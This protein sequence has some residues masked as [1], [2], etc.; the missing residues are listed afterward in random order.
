MTSEVM[1]N[2]NILRTLSQSSSKF[3][4][5]DQQRQNAWFIRYLKETRDTAFDSQ[6]KTLNYG[7]L[8]AGAPL[9]YLQR[10]EINHTF[11]EDSENSNRSRA[12]IYEILQRNSFSRARE[13][14]LW[15]AVKVDHQPRKSLFLKKAGKLDISQLLAFEKIQEGI[16]T[17]KKSYSE[18]N[19]EF[20]KAK[21]IEL[22]SFN[23][24]N[25]TTTDLQ[26]FGRFAQLL[27]PKELSEL[28]GES[29]TF[30]N[31][32]V[33]SVVTPT[34]S[35]TQLTEIYKRF[36]S[37]L[38]ESERDTK[39]VNTQLFPALSSTDLLSS[40]PHFIWTEHRDAL[41]EASDMF[42][43]AQMSALHELIKPGKWNSA[44]MSSILTN[45]PKCLDDDPPKKVMENLDLILDGVETVPE[46]FYDI[47]DKL[48]MIPRHLKMAWLETSLADKEILNTDDLLD[49]PSKDAALKE[50]I[51]NPDSTHPLSHTFIKFF[52]NDDSSLPSLVLAGLSCKHI[53]MI[54][55]YDSLEV[56]AL[57]R[58][59]VDLYGDLMPSS[60]R[61][62]WA[63][64]VREFLMF[65]ASVLNI[66]MTTETE[67]LSLLNT[68]EIKT[69]GGE[70]LLTWGG[71]VLSSIV[72]PEVNHE[73]LM[74]VGLTKP[75]AFLSNGVKYSCV[76]EMAEAMLG[77]MLHHEQGVMDLTVLAHTHNLLPF[78]GNSTVGA[79]AADIKNYLRTVLRPEDKLMCLKKDDRMVVR[80]LI[81]KAFGSP[82]N[83]NSLDLVE[84]GDLLIVLKV[85]DLTKVDPTS[86]RM[87]AEELAANTKY[88]DLITESRHSTFPVPYHEACALWLGGDQGPESQESKDYNEQWTM[89]S[90]FIIVGNY[91]Q[92]KVLENGDA[93]S[94]Q[95]RE[96]RRR[97]READGTYDF[98][99]NYTFVM[100]KLNEMFQA[101]ELNEDQKKNAT[102]IIIGTQELLAEY[103][104]AVLGLERGNLTQN[105]VLV[106][107]QQYR[108]SGN[109]TAEQS[110]LISQLAIDTQA[111]MV[112]GLAPLLGI[113]AADLQITQETYDQILA[114]ETFSESLLGSS[115]TTPAPQQDAPARDLLDD[116]DAQTQDTTSSSSSEG[117]SDASSST[118]NT[119]TASQVETVSTS[120][121]A[122][123]TVSSSSTEATSTISTAST[124]TVSIT[125]T[126]STTTV[127]T[128]S[129]ESTSA[130]STESTTTATTAS[131]ESTTT[132]P[133]NYREGRD[134]V[135]QSSAE[136]STVSTPTEAT[137]STTVSTTSEPVSSTESTK[138]SSSTERSVSSSSTEASNTTASTLEDSLEQD[139]TTPASVDDSLSSVLKQNELLNLET[140]SNYEPNTAAFDTI[141]HLKNITL[142]CR[143]LRASKNAAAALSSMCLKKMSESEDL[144]NCL[145]VL[146]HIP[147]PSSSLVPVWSVVKETIASVHQGEDTPLDRDMML[148]LENLMPA[149]VS[150]SPDLID[151]AK[152]NIDGL[153]LIERLLSWEDAYDVVQ[154]YITVNSKTESNPLS[155][156]ELGALGPLLCGLR[157]DHWSTLIPN[158]TFPSLVTRYLAYLDCPV[159]A[160][161]AGHLS[162]LLVFAYGSPDTWSTA[163]VLSMGWMVS[164]LSPELLVTIPSHAMEGLTGNAA[165][166]FTA[167]QWTSLTAGQLQYLSPHTASFVSVQ[168]LATMDSAKMREIRAAVGE[169][170]MVV[171]EMEKMFGSG[172]PSLHCS[173]ILVIFAVVA[174]AL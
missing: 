119:T 166:H 45:H 167:L 26:N 164:T 32:V 94:I 25:M 59:H 112:I 64:Q 12:F 66:T 91:L 9:E 155:R 163:D 127:S 90:R 93:V 149:I 102:N 114:M 72:N 143:V 168:K 101:G 109:M 132:L 159:P 28:G 62:C 8:L 81:M 128:T 156:V 63:K 40:K 43:R 100:A 41:L 60:T 97:K 69:I 82:E 84:L 137:S 31:S 7:H 21:F 80:N 140:F 44:N 130:A 78:A 74:E 2:L 153:S 71:S 57:Y 96:A 171:G 111:R 11:I 4:A 103:S 135:S 18:V 150:E 162:D 98:K 138:A 123:S 154:R 113:T 37:Q 173:I 106:V 129:R 142:S 89:Y 79:E 169:D 92:F 146:G 46:K 121:T 165:K 50:V 61:K 87:A 99:S 19:A 48:Q 35:L 65:K 73:V 77:L 5:G 172:S 1:D 33:V 68:A 49:K 147:W 161:V 29:A 70:I 30:D 145:D 148:Q 85:E 158:A 24:T 117:N 139:S 152:E 95:P 141:P 13:Q 86:L 160:G 15:E 6:L 83:W 116:G 54:E 52:S 55:V 115:T 134:E 38:E 124:T 47:A 22:E 36:K 56:L 125:S 67:L 133:E 51:V 131:T 122:S 20:F 14:V 126:A 157:E 108:N 105:E 53:E 107:L 76:K 42:T 144:T 104:F 88:S 151:V 17:L 110:D 16:P 58:Y 170:P 10:F 3:L 27:S 39:V 23:L 120:S 174:F 136:S 118:S 75:L 34:M